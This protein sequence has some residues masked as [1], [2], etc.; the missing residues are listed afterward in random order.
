V[1]EEVAEVEK[2]A[3]L[4]AAVLGRP[5]VVI[6]P[7]LE[8]DPAALDSARQTLAG[9]GLEAGG[10][11]VACVGG[12]AHV[13]IKTWP[14]EHWG[15][16]LAEWARRYGRRFLF[17]GL[18]EERPAAE[19][20]RAAMAES[21]G[22]G[23]A[24]H[25]AV[26]WLEPGGTL[27]DLLALTQLSA[28]YVGHDT[29]PMHVAAA[30]GKPVA[31]VFGG[32]TWPRFRPA[33]EPSVALLVGVPCLGCGWACSFS[34]SHCI[35]QVPPDEVL[36]AVADVE[37]G[38]VTGREA[39]V[40]EPSRQ[41]LAQMTGEAAVYVRQQVREKATVANRLRAA[42][43]ALVPP[44]QSE[45]AAGMRA[46][47]HAARE[48]AHRAAEAAE[49]RAAETALLRQ[50]LELRAS[51]SHRLD[52][53]LEA[54]TQE[55]NRLRDDIRGILRDLER[56]GG[57]TAGGNG[58]HTPDAVIPPPSDAPPPP[59]SETAPADPPVAVVAE[60][61]RED[62]IALLR[63]AIERLEG[64]VRELEPPL[65]TPRRVRRS[66]REIVVD[67]VIGSKY[68]S[69]RP[70]LPRPRVTLVTPVL[71]AAGTIR[72]TIESV[73]A[74]DYYPLE[75]VI[76]DGG[77]TDGTADI[78][79]EYEGRLRVATRGKAPAS[80]VAAGEAR[81]MHAVAEAFDQAAG[82]VLS[83]L[84]P[85][86]VLEHGGVA[87]VADYFAR[88]R[89]VN[90]VY[91][92]DALLHPGGWKFPAPPQPTADVYHLLRLARE[93]GASPMAFTSGAA[94]TW[95]WGRWTAVSGGRQTGNCGRGWHVGSSCA[96]SR[97]TSDRSAPT[98]PAGTTRT[99]RRTSP[100]RARR[101]SVHSDSRGGCAVG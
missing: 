68:Y 13:S 96:G 76:V 59:A 21:L 72:Q 85:G 10:Y 98:A 64:R 26:L 67:L 97:G 27:D 49:R 57:A 3:A 4:C 75:Y 89:G 39:R 52:A 19:A 16:V 77:S 92:E 79:R 93:G 8:A 34:T 45:W 56:S 12:T 6:D 46:E 32:G 94:P 87:R 73:L 24:A 35:K 81:L 38:R 61:A 74:Q 62:E 5:P 41:L 20:V 86:D 42:E 80:D 101:S 40:L 2:N 37:E 23:A 22:E 71:N 58:K 33:V 7:R 83:F 84:P 28:G 91:F 54:Q 1:N 11:W 60:A 48:E 9:L 53:A 14:A 36:A 95:R 78:L 15:T 66:L 100:A 51:E 44:E 18:P 99:T 90:V 30:M 29:G 88:H 31:A 65:A 55:V 70:P 82:E 17:V 47:L 50:D 43:R 69:R 25:H 63:T